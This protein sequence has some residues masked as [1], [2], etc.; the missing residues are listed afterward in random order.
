[1]EDKSHLDTHSSTV[2]TMRGEGTVTNRRASV[3]R[4]GTPRPG[5]LNRSPNAAGAG[6][7]VR[8]RLSGILF[9]PWRRVGG[10]G[11]HGGFVAV[12]APVEDAVTSSRLLGSVSL[13]G[14]RSRSRCGRPDRGAHRMMGP[15]G[16]SGSWH[17]GL[18]G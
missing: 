18:R 5:D 10:F 11:I 15:V 14:R 12:I 1:M 2:V 4:R 6:P 16:G 13:G 3:T 9:F 17:N 7:G 8:P